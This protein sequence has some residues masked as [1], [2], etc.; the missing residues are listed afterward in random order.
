MRTLAPLLFLPLLAGCG[1]S[2]WD[3]L[4]S[5]GS[6]ARP[7]IAQPASA[8]PAAISRATAPP[9]PAQPDP[10]CL[11]VAKND[12]SG[13]GFDQATQGK[14]ALRSYQ[15]CVGIFGPLAAK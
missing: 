13:A 6:P 5:F 15:Q 2:Q 7:A 4:T 9:A 14:V 1:A 12:A 10:F 3:Y 11:A 8:Q